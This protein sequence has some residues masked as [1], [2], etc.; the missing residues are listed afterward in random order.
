[1]GFSDIGYSGQR[2]NNHEYRLKV[3]VGSDIH[4]VTGNAVCG[5]IFLIPGDSSVEI[6][7]LN[8]PD[9]EAG[10]TS[11]FLTEAGDVYGCGRNHQGQ[12]GIG[13]TANTETP[14]FVTGASL[15]SAVSGIFACNYNTFFITPAGDVY[16]CG[17]NN[18]GQLG[19]GDT[20]RRLVPNYI[21]GATQGSAVSSIAA[22]VDNSLF[23]TPNGDV[24]GCGYNNYGQLGLGDT[25][26]RLVPNYITGAAQGSAV[27]VVSSAQNSSLFLTTAGDVLGCGHNAECQLGLGDITQREV[28]NYITGAAQGSAVA[29]ISA[30]RENSLFLTPN[31]DVYGCG[32]N[33][34]GQLGLGN[35]TS[36]CFPAYV[37]GVAEGSAVAD[38]SSSLWNSFFL[39]PNGDVYGC[40][41]NNNGQLGLG[42]TT[43]RLVPNYI[44]GAAQG[45]AVAEISSAT[46]NSLFLTTAG[47]A[48]GCGF[49]N[50]GQLGLGDTTQRESPTYITGASQGSETKVYIATATSTATTSSVYSLHIT[51]PPGWTTHSFASLVDTP[52]L[53]N[54]FVLG[55][56]PEVDIPANTAI[57]I[58]G[59]VSSTTADGPLPFED[60]IP[61]QIHSVF[62]TAG[63]VTWD[64]TTSTVTL[65]PDN[66]IPA[67]SLSTVS[68]DMVNSAAA[69]AAITTT[70]S[71]A[72]MKNATLS[73]AGAIVAGGISNLLTES[74]VTVI[75][76]ESAMLAL[77]PPSVPTPPAPAPIYYVEAEERFYVYDHTMNLW[78]FFQFQF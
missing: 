38:I 23:L 12:L 55:L 37:S 50:Y 72:G 69:Q 9:S 15:G 46:F 40:G 52:S 8:S 30:S 77:T 36:I 62:I 11:F 67:A 20:A 56:Q 10:D 70:L 22:S 13:T 27:A 39:T 78:R 61:V 47:S 42:D 48:Y 14:T 71:A 60:G 31:G 64:S 24:Y 57:K 66:V 3:R 29:D 63:A 26:Q 32:Y 74:M 16:G 73:P 75:A 65:T 54:S 28:P 25:T 17:H 6:I 41:H 68:F 59:L 1:M 2:L 34:Y 33:S 18:N 21:T 76:S 7:S 58:Q 53:L 5:E 35:T 44:T 43:Q 4:K 19:L 49:N 51:E 45:S